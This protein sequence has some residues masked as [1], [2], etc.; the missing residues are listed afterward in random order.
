MK[1]FRLPVTLIVAA[2]LFYLGSCDSGKKEKTTEVTTDSIAPAP[3]P[4]P[5]AT[6]AGPSS[7]MIIRHKVADYATWKT[8]YESHD[9]SRL[10]NGLHNYIIAR[11]IDDPNTVL[12]ALK[13]DDA[14]KAKAFSTSQDLKDRMKKLGVSGPPVT[15]F[16][17]TIQNDTTAIQETTRLMMRH[18]VKDWDAWKQTFESNRAI[19]TDAGLTDRAIGHTVGDNHQVTVVFSVTDMAK[20]KAFLNSQELKDKMKASGVEGPPDAFFYKVSQKY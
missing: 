5:V 9:S 20:A 7:L 11:G 3:A 2:S 8:G 1:Q 12:V 16:L 4:A 13:M 6:T 17:E 10:A 15:D 19:R 18:K 14:A